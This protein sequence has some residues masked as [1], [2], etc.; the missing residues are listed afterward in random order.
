MTTSNFDE[1][2]RIVQRGPVSGV[3]VHAHMR[4]GPHAVI[5]HALDLTIIVE[6]M[7]L[8][9]EQ[10]RRPP[11]DPPLVVT[12]AS[13]LERLRE[14]GVKSG[15]GSRLIGR[16]AVY[17]SF[18]RLRNKNYLR[19]ITHRVDNKVSGVSYEFY[20]FPA[21]NPDPLPMPPDDS[22]ASMQVGATSGIA[23]SG[24]AGNR[25]SNR[26]SRSSSQVKAASG[27]AGSGNARNRSAD[28]TFPQVGATSGNAG[29]PPHPPEEVTTSS[30]YPLAATKRKRAPQAEG[31]E[32]GYAA[33]DL[34]A[35]ADVLQQLPDPW[36]QGKLNAGKLAPKLLTVMAEQGWPGIQ[37]VD[38][39]TLTR[40]LTKNPHKVTNPYRLLASDRVP[41]LPRYA[42]VVAA[43]Q[44][45]Q[46]ASPDAMCPKHPKYRAGSR[47]IPCRT[48]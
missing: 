34:E 37:D 29:S 46:A 45:A 10:A 20:E 44:S 17:E 33:E 11:S 26:T 9:S 2:G 48:A 43:E 19:R 21:W 35:A 3:T 8:L 7:F 38:R 47:C 16:D 14:A 31:E 24:N 13:V 32:A 15:N 27:N 41:N 18:A 6:L 22:D 28:T 4:H 39:L 5:G 1:T 40:Q 36:T 30:P 42:V 23:G 12:P 25:S